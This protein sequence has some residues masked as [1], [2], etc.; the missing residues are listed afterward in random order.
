M[1]SL[2]S[3]K[4][5]EYLCFATLIRSSILEE[6]ISGLKNVIIAATTTTTIVPRVV[7]FLLTL[8]A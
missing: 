3:E 4:P 6:K 8:N 7:Q 1:R 2:P 5:E